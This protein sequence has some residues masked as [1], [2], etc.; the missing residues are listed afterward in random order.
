M[1]EGKVDFKTGNQ[2][3][4]DVSS[5]RSIFKA[6]SLFGGV[7]LYDIIVGIIKTKCVAIILGP[8]GMGIQGLLHSGTDLIRTL[9]SFGLSASAVRDVSE[10][11]GTGDVERIGK[12]VAVL[13]KLVW[14]T[15]ILGM[16]VTMVFSP[17]LSKTLFGNYDY[18][19]SFILLSIILLLT[20]LSNG[21]KVVLQGMRKLQFLAKSTAIGATIGLLVTVP[22]YYLFGVKGIVPTLILQSVT[23]LCL[24]WYFSRKVPIKKVN[25][26]NKEAF[27]GGKTMLKMGV[28]MS[29]SGILSTAIAYLIRGYLGRIGG[30]GEVGLYTSGF[31][32]MNT[33]VGMIFTAM[34]TDYYPRLSAV[35][36]D[37][38]KCRNVIN[39]QAEIAILIMGPVVLSCILFMPFIVQIL[40]SKEFLPATDFILWGVLG[41]IFKASSWSISFI[42]LAKAESKLFIINETAINITHLLLQ[43]VGYKYFGLTGLG[44]AYTLNYFIYFIQ[45]YIIARNRYDF[46]FNKSF[47][48]VY[49][50]QLGLVVIAYI[51]GKIWSSQ[52]ITIIL[53]VLL[54][55]SFI[56]SLHEMNKRMDLMAIINKRVRKN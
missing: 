28:A 2:S 3:K 35:N 6:T 39:Q 46:A 41:L 32:L 52:I 49:G 27:E 21:Q 33:Y 42:F 44:I 20:Q 38:D 25:V 47:I 48:K 31:T 9:T 16:V 15:G 30:V 17:V 53:I 54:V 37:N 13:R 29:V 36:K 19:V 26:T 56:Y 43:M 14:V 5:Y 4:N 51:I 40:Y 22:L 12:T 11:N 50:V 45:V 34:G 24:S 18:T 10:A 8:A 55:A 7:Q 23:T 1:S